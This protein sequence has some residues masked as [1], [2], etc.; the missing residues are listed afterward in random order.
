MCVCVY[1][2][3]GRTKN[4]VISCI[5]VMNA[6]DL[7]RIISNSVCAC[8]CVY[9]FHVRLCHIIYIYMYVF[10]NVFLT[11]LLYLIAYNI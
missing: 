7:Q 9:L 1:I 4:G 8:V 10:K 6:I 5:F 3:Y 11:L 2:H